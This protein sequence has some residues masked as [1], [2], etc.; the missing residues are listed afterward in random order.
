VGI[1]VGQ[2]HSGR[3]S[4][5][6]VAEIVAELDAENEHSAPSRPQGPK[7]DQPVRQ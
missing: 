3:L 4:I 1:G 2:A 5:R 7:I 6:S